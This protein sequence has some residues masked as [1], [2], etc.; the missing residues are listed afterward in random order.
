[1]RQLNPC[2]LETLISVKGMVTRCSGIIPEMLE[3]VFICQSCRAE[4]RC[5]V[6]CGKIDEPTQCDNCQQKF[7][8]RIAHNHCQFANKQ[9]IRLQES[10]DQIP[11]GETPHT[12]T[13]FV[14]DEVVDA[15]KPGDRVTVT[16]VYKAAPVRVNP[17]NRS[18]KSIYKTYILGL[19]VE[20]ERGASGQRDRSESA[21]QVAEE[22]A[23]DRTPVEELEA[24]AADPDV[25]ENLVDS[26]A[27]S[28]WGMRDVKRG[29]LCQLFGAVPKVY[30]GGSTRG[31]L[32][33]LLVGDPGVSKSQLLGYMNK[34][35]PRGIYTSGRG[36][37]AVGLTAY[38]TRDP[39]TKEM[40]LESGA[41]VLSDL[42]VC[43]IDE[44]DKM[45]DNAR[46]MLHEVMEQQTVSVAKAGIISTLNA[47][48]SVL[49]AANPVESRYNRGKNIMDNINLP[50]SLVS[51]FD[52]LYLILDD[53]DEGKDRQLAKHL[54]SLHF[55]SVPEPP[56]SRIPARKLRDL[57]AHAR[58][59][60]HPSISD[61]ASK[62]IVD[63]YVDMRC[64]GQAMGNK[65][66]TISATPRQLESLVRIAEA[67]ARMR[68]STSVEARDVEEAVRL[69]KSAWA[70]AAE[71]ST[72]VLDMS[73]INTGVSEA[74]RQNLKQVE[75]AVA[76]VL[77]K[78]DSRA[79][80]LQQL[81]TLVE[82]QL[83]F[84][85]PQETIAQGMQALPNVTVRGARW[86]KTGRAV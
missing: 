50:P 41:L 66:T 9:T 57:V 20:V 37:S 31:E 38:V 14:S 2:D 80:T 10:P 69:M 54:V 84:S 28:V 63:A 39:E 34:I 71:P 21:S 62:A 70:S 27:P 16:G 15:C 65:R 44:F 74:S 73:L 59:T 85:V 49:A 32:N 26:I 24:L 17:R 42:G 19:H 83:G 13:V 22:S 8:L 45:S 3:A 55:E 35:A 7:T 64:R 30:S 6:E 82:D 72:G 61:E 33:V 40:V 48:T 79:G 52:L 11:E 53:V 81:G 58:Q 68:L 43:C 18:I 23:P 60:C 78:V 75:Q 86:S 5:Q 1:M 76:E 47:R 36:S 51:R 12:C 77:R 29:L 25:Y 67:L 56:R 4:H 46:S